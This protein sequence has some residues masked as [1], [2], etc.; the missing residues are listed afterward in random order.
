MPIYHPRQLHQPDYRLRSQPSWGGSNMTHWWPSQL[1]LRMSLFTVPHVPWASCPFHIPRRNPQAG[2]VSDTGNHRLVELAPPPRLFENSSGKQGGVHGTVCHWGKQL[3]WAVTHDRRDCHLGLCNPS[4]SNSAATAGRQGLEVL[5]YPKD[6]AALVR[7][8][9][10]GPLLTSLALL[11]SLSGNLA[12]TPCPHLP[13]SEATSCQSI[14][15][16][17]ERTPQPRSPA[18]C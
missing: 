2:Q 14:P 8:Q 10:L 15:K 16:R 3:A 12:L 11:P 9:V 5:F 18:L 17:P 13:H 6:A 1:S 4:C 7:A